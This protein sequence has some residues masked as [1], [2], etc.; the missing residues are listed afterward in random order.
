MLP[1]KRG[2]DCHVILVL[3]E[4]N[5]VHNF[6]SCA[7]SVNLLANSLSHGNLENGKCFITAFLGGFKGV[8]SNHSHWS[9]TDTS[10]FSTDEGGSGE[11]LLH[12]SLG[13]FEK[14]KVDP[15][16][17]KYPAELLDT[18]EWF[19]QHTD[20][21]NDSFAAAAGAGRS[22]LRSASAVWGQR[23]LAFSR[24]KIWSL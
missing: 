5:K 9:F 21:N 20:N 11:V 8:H 3:K 23:Q 15:K 12:E 7:F 2:Q 24:G 22:V 13:P 6:A 18:N 4:K 16:H 14:K 17:Y 19:G 10:K 1:K